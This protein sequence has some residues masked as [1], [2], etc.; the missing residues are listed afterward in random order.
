[1]KAARFTRGG[2]RDELHVGARVA[3]S[4]G[5]QIEEIT[6]L[7]GRSD[8]SDDQGDQ[9]VVHREI[10]EI[11][12]IRGQGDHVVLHRE[13]RRPRRSGESSMVHREVLSTW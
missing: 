5:V 6:S 12:E 10:T 1:V 13:A 9:V 4:R 2:E 3:R 11:R 8:R 7:Q